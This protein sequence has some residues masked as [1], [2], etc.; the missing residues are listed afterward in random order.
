[1][2]T[3][4]G[5]PQ[6]QIYEFGDFRLDVSRRLLTARD[7]R[8][9]PLTPK[10]FETLL[11]LVRHG[12]ALLGKDELMRAVWPD[13]AVEENNLS[14]S[15]SALRRALG[16]RPGQHR[17]IATVQG[18]GFRFVAPV[19]TRADEDDREGSAEPKSG[20]EAGRSEAA[21]TDSPRAA[22]PAGGL[23]TNLRLVALAA[24]LAVGVAG[25]II[26]RAR[27][28]TAPLTSP[29]P[30]GA[31]STIT[32]AAPAKSIAVLPFKPLVPEGREEALEVGMAD[33]LIAKLGRIGGLSV[34][35]LGA[36]RR[37]GGLEQDPAAAGRELGV[38]AVLD[39]T[40]QRAG[41]RVGVT[42]RLL[43]VG[44]GR[45][46]W[47][48]RFE[49]PFTDIFSVQDSISAQVAGSLRPRLTRAEERRLAR[50]YTENAEAYQLYLRGRYHLLKNTRS[51]IQAAISHFRQAIELDP[52]YG[53]AYAGLANAYHALA[54]PGELPPTE[55][56]PQAKAAA[57]K[58]V[59]IDDGLA[60]AHALLG[61]VIFWYDW[62]WD[63]A[64]REFRRALELDP[65]SADAHYAYADLLSYTGRHEEALAEIKRARELDPLNLRINTIE[66]ALLIN[67]GRADE[68]LARLQKTL[69][70]DPHYWYARQY[71]ANAYIEKGMYGEAIAEA[72]K[73]KELSESATRPRAFLGYALAK[74][75][76][77]ADARAE[78]EGLL[79]L[80]K[81]RHVSPYNIAMIYNGLGE[82]DDALEWLELGY[83]EREPRM[84]FLKVEPKWNNLRDDPRFRDLVRRV[85][86]PQ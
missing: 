84:V 10:P 33:T 57:R 7:G 16:E 26:W 69:E 51:E 81:E 15:I 6:P 64:E 45:Q 77:R 48:G 75:G 11:Y 20:P 42:A 78:L 86:L 12:G 21:E 39:G 14:Q 52:S 49:A 58:A 72:R 27:T 79:R 13:A 60:E 35:P 38:E 71:V 53:L 46:L 8:V 66:G 18:H 74:S 59:E 37:Y 28:V 73:A 34:R 36:V 63:A 76:R 2:K 68:A 25:L 43:S 3:R 17:Y 82:R 61:F 65:N 47:E 70:L 23:R 9:V 5:E 83:R 31:P 56:L 80:S 19:T 29:T 32:A 67:A 4:V 30:P 41:D 22:R 85:G 44:D 50:H 24:L 1:L 54:G 62:D 40:V 55:L